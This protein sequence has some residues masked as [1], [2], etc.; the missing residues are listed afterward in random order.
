V[1]TLLLGLGNELYGDD[2]VG[3]DVVR[4]LRE[5]AKKNKR[6]AAHLSDVEMEE[7]SLS[8][9]ALLDVITGYDRLILVDTI[10]RKAPSPGRIHLL[11]ENEIRAIPGP[12]PHYI[13]VSQT[14]EIGR[15]LGLHVPSK[16]LIVAIEAKNIYRLGE[17]LSQEMKGKLPAIVQKV[18]NIL[19]SN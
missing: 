12:S 9:L 2:G 7:C 1:K 6:L 16:I 3:I 19:L 5:K 17:G 10:K 4:K 18:K 11:E 14:I 13:S 8:G 15:K